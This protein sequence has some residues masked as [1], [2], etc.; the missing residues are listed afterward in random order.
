MQIRGFPFVPLDTAFVSAGLVPCRQ[1]AWGLYCTVQSLFL[2]TTVCST[3]YQQYFHYAAIVPCDALRQYFHCTEHRIPSGTGLLLFP[4]FVRN[5]ADSF[6]R[7]E[8]RHSLFTVRNTIAIR[9]ES[10][11]VWY[12]DIPFYCTGYC[13]S[14]TRSDGCVRGT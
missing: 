10:S 5:S 3:V 1:L 12:S 11:L 14:L 9:T 6:L 2:F 13:S 4:S 7:T 8:S